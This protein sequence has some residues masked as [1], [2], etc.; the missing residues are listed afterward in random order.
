MQRVDIGNFSICP[1]QGERKM[2][3]EG[4]GKGSK[5]KLPQRETTHGADNKEWLIEF[6]SSRQSPAKTSISLRVC[7]PSATCRNVVSRGRKNTFDAA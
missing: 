4:C 2:R 7:L 6:P 5:S 3:I 1:S